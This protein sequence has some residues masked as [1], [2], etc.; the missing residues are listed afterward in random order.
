M[1]RGPSAV[2]ATLDGLVEELRR[3]GLPISV[4][5]KV[6][7]AAAL[8]VVDLADREAVKRGLGATLVKNG[9]HG[10]MYD[11]VFDLFF[12]GPPATPEPTAGLDALDD[13]TV[14]QL[15]LE[16]IEAGEESSLR[17]RG[18][19]RVLVDRHAGL[20]PGQ[21]V[22][23]TYY[24]YRVMR[25]LDTDALLAG[26]VE[27][28]E[29]RQ[30]GS[31]GDELNRRLLVE[32]LERGISSFRQEL[33]A[34]IRRRLVADRG[35]GAVAR[36]L[37]HQLP[38][39]V[40][41]LTA[42]AEQLRLLG[43]VL[44]PLARKLAARI[45]ARRRH[46]RRG[47][48]DFRKTIRGSLSTGGV[49]VDVHF[50]KPRPAKPEL[51]VLADISGSV[52]AFAAFVL[53]LTYALRSQ[54]ARVSSY[55]F[56][57]G[58]DDVS[59]LIDKSTGIAEVAAEINRRGLGV[60]L[61]GRSD[62]GNAIDTFWRQH[63]ARL[64]HRTTVLVFG[65]ARGNYHSP[66]TEVLGRIAQRAGHVYWLNPEPRAAWDT[67]DSV[68]GQYAR[69]CDGVFECRNVRQLEAFVERLA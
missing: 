41:F 7:A 19:A 31:T 38:E 21:P 8:A 47:S 69:H 28:A 27:R 39:D 35:A 29:Q 17:Q 56:V 14:R 18:L 63:G 59:E 26:F 15:V 67:G 64:R 52:A 1:V 24:L 42:S 23:G 43:E 33:E 20:E 4:A 34:E 3:V 30:P 22:A 25:A 10:S 45:G 53:Q 68:I 16:S 37:R 55:V 36:T 11:T 58:L 57:D 60:W 62:Y 54:F 9:D 44:A 51:V 13:A 6:D 48:V 49:P 50:H 12:G 32:G 61:D 46:A 40:D 66:R 2:L 5:E 65:D